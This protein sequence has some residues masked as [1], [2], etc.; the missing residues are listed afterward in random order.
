MRTAPNGVSILDFA[1]VSLHPLEG[2]NFGAEVVQIR[3]GVI[4][5]LTE[6]LPQTPKF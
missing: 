2:E 6:L 1:V 3:A 4:I 5:G